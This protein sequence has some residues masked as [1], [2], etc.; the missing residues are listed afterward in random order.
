MKSHASVKSSG[1]EALRATPQATHVLVA[2][3]ESAA[4]GRQAKQATRTSGLLTL[5]EA[6]VAAEGRFVDTLRIEADVWE[7]VR[8]LHPY[9]GTPEEVFAAMGEL[10]H[11]GRVR[12]VFDIGADPIAWLGE[13]GLVCEVDPPEVRSDFCARRVR[14]FANRETRT[15]MPHAIV[16]PEGFEIRFLWDA[17]E[18]VV[19]IGWV[20]EASPSMSDK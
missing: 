19:V 3:D 6:V 18:E 12:R 14:T 2:L 13:Q 9:A 16:L 15:Y 4:G 11:W 7:A 17:E 1:D 8:S 5:E 20:G 10:A